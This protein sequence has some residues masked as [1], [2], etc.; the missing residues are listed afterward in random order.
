[1]V[2]LMDDAVEGLARGRRCKA[3][4]ILRNL[5]AGGRAKYQR[6]GEFHRLDR[7]PPEPR[8]ALER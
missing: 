7:I 2:R 5:R 3:H 4:T 6:P 8:A 1:M